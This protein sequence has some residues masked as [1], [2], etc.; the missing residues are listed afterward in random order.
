MPEV[1]GMQMSKMIKRLLH[2]VKSKHDMQD[3]NQILNSTL[4]EHYQD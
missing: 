3:A 1:D 2:K 4:I